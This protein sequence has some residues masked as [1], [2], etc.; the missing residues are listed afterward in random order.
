MFGSRDVSNPRSQ[1][2]SQ[3]EYNFISRLDGAPDAKA[4]EAVIRESPQQL[5]R[6][7]FRLLNQISKDQT[8]QYL[9]TLLDD[10]LQEDKARVEVL[11]AAHQGK[12]E[13][14]WDHLLALLNRPAGFITN[15]TARIVAKVACWS[16]QPMTGSDLQLYLT[17]LKD[18]L[19]APG[20]EYVQSVARCLQMLLRIDDYRLAFAHLD[21][22]STLVSVLSGRVNFQVQYQ[23][24]FCLWVLSFNPGVAEKLSKF[25]V[26]PILADILTDAQK[27]KVS[28]IILAVFRV[29]NTKFP[30]VFLAQQLIS[31]FF[32]E[33]DREARRHSGG[34]GELHLDGPVQ[35][36]EAAR[37]HRAEKVRRRGHSGKEKHTHFSKFGTKIYFEIRNLNLNLNFKL[38]LTFIEGNQRFLTLFSLTICTYYRRTLSSSRSA[39]R[40]A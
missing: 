3:E 36:H 27:E 39:W 2:I 26:I 30:T 25:G 17:W 12:K 32:A 8:I 22:V 5:A 18:Q 40:P 1:M 34:E 7:F 20:N 21:G 24:S 4:R 19:K 10:L 13:T 33:H 15:M 6:T 37:V 31:P 11:K 35:G 9:L 28:R 38:L 29:S 14:V 23:L 16:A